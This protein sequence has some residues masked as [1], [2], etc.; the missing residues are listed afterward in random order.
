MSGKVEAT[1]HGAESDALTAQ[2]LAAARAYAVRVGE[3]PYQHTHTSLYCSKCGWSAE[4]PIPA[5]V[6]EIDR[7]A[8]TAAP[9]PE[10]HSHAKRFSDVELAAE[11]FR[12]VFQEAESEVRGRKSGDPRWIPIQREECLRS[13]VVERFATLPHH[14]AAQRHD[15]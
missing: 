7:L 11:L 5:L 4:S 9:V 15:N 10:H 14:D 3:C 13:V 6:A 8:A 2:Q 12:Q 1:F